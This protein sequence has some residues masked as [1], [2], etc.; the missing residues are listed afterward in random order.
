VPEAALEA[1]TA[2]LETYLCQYPSTTLEVFYAD[3]RVTGRVSLTAEDL[4]LRLAPIAGGGTAFGPALA[5][6][7]EDEE[8]PAC[9]VYLTDLYGSF[10]EEPPTMPVI[11]LVFGN[12]EPK[13]P[14]GRVVPLPY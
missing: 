5:A 1:V 12:A 9:V 11:W 10:P 14:F 13:A 2:E 4:P 6:L 8:P 7:D 3:A